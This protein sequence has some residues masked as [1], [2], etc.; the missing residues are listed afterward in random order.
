MKIAKCFFHP[1]KAFKRKIR[2][3]FIDHRPPSVFSWLFFAT[4]SNNFWSFQCRWVGHLLWERWRGETYCICIKADIFTL[5]EVRYCFVVFPWGT[6][7]TQA[8]FFIIEGN[9]IQ[10]ISSICFWGSSRQTVLTVANINN[11]F[12]KCPFVQL[13]FI[14]TLVFYLLSLTDFLK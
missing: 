8:N 13:T 5:W 4:R 14:F 6:E 12:E 1:L 2:S 7:T 3:G 11:G 9:I 10:E